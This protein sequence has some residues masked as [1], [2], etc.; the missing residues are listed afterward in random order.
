M[1]RKSLF[2]AMLL[3]TAA[4]VAA[5]QMEWTS[6]RPDGQSPLGVL[7]GQLLNAGE[8]RIGYT[9]TQMDFKGV[10]A[11]SD[12]IALSQTYDYYQVAPLTRQNRTHQVAV[13][14]APSS[15]LTLSARL[16][17]AQRQREQLTSDGGFFATEAKELGDL[18]VSG[19]YDVFHQGNY[20]AH[21][22]LGARVPTGAY[23][24]KGVTPFSSPGKEALP[25]DMRVGGGT[26]AVL[27][28][29]TV[30][31]QNDL[32]SV[33]AQVRATLNVGKNGSKFSPGDVF[34]YNFWAAYNVNDYVSVSARAHY[35]RWG[36]IRGADPAL[37]PAVDPGND[38]YWLQGRRLD[39]PVGLSISLPQGMRLG[40]NRISVEYIY[41]V[42]QHYEGV[43]V[44]A[45]WGISVGWQAIFQP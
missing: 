37:D 42:S 7:D 33:G 44:G 22:Q 45:D 9:F 35:Q 16:S 12:S 10:W 43:Q 36:A 41:P 38:G 21:L 25:Y 8:F 39:I 13:A 27:P 40:G 30:L 17:Y 23:D 34:D 19:L 6:K 20:R 5:Q 28:G 32:A 1:V 11:G 3:A 26:F 29:L 14:Y 31:A 15:D 24:T 4:P 2:V 18:E